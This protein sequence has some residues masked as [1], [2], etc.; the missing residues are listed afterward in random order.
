MCNKSNESRYDDYCYFSPELLIVLF[1]LWILRNG[2]RNLKSR[3]SDYDVANYY[4][5]DAN[6]IAQEDSD[7]K[8]FELIFFLH[9]VTE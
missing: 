1:R 8:P 6:K 2:M 3:Y 7:R 9:K 4:N 5:C